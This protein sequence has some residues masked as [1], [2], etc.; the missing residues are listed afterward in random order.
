MAIRHFPL[1]KN[2]FFFIFS[3]PF[4]GSGYDALSKAFFN[5]RNFS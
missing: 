4:S 2:T 1:T 3:I 5:G